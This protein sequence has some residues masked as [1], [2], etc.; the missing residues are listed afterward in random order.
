MT[1]SSGQCYRIGNAAVRFFGFPEGTSAA[2][3]SLVADSPQPFEFL[4][5]YYSISIQPRE[6]LDWRSVSKESDVVV[7]GLDEFIW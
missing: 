6:G 2:T 7:L 4:G 1:E 5:D 3:C